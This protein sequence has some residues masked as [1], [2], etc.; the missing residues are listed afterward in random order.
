MLRLSKTQ[1]RQRAALAEKTL[2]TAQRAALLAEIDPQGQL[3]KLEAEIAKRKAELVEVAQENA[4]VVKA[5]EARLGIR[6]A[7]YS[8]DDVTGTLHHLGPSEAKEG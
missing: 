7:E 6:L 1:E 8:F 4:A 3:R 5:V 2:L